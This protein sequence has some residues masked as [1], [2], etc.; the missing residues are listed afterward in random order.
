MRE[1]IHHNEAQQ[2]HES[3]NPEFKVGMLVENKEYMNIQREKSLSPKT[4]MKIVGKDT[5]KDWRVA[6]EW[7]GKTISITV[8]ND[9]IAPAAESRPETQH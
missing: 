2:N 6:L 8:R 3:I 5:I 9:E 7:E 4:H 1:N